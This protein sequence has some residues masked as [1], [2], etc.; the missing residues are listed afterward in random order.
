MELLTNAK[1]AVS[2]LLKKKINEK[3]TVGAHVR[4][5]HVHNFYIFTCSVPVQ[6]GGL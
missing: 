2:D 6:S 1:R 4:A 3:V 5:A